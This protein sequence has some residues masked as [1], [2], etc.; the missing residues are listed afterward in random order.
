MEREH[1]GSCRGSSPLSS[2]TKKHGHQAT[3]MPHRP[4]I[5]WTGGAQNPGPQ[6]PHHR[7]PSQP[8][9]PSRLLRK[10]NRPKKKT[11]HPMPRK[12]MSND[13][14]HVKQDPKPCPSP[15]HTPLKPPPHAV[16]IPTASAIRPPPLL[17]TSPHATY[18]QRLLCPKRRGT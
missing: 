15:K 2:T 11:P 10:P 18:S 1:V 14:D 12:K 17:P 9:A 3:T 13:P 6:P 5:P 8:N 4:R 7:H 16:R